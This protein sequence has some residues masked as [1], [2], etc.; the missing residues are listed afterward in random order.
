M[1]PPPP[2][3]KVAS[4]TRPCSKLGGTTLQR[5]EEG[6]AQKCDHQRFEERKAGF[7]L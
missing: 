3:I 7:S 2:L 4:N 1:I 5:R 6:V